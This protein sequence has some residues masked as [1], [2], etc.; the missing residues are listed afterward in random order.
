MQRRDLIKSAIIGA[1]GLQ[2]AACTTAITSDQA[3]SD[4]NTKV[5]NK[6]IIKPKPLKFGDT[7]AIIAPGTN[8]PTPEALQKVQEVI[9]WLGLKAKY[10]EYLR[11]DFGY[12]TRT[13]QTRATEFMQA[14]AD[15]SVS[16]VFCIRGGYGC[17]QIL[18]LIDYDLIRNNPKIFAGYSDIT[19]LHLAIAQRSRLVTLHAPVMKSEFT[20]FTAEHFKD[21]I[22]AKAEYPLLLQ[23]P[24]SKSGIR[25]LFPTRTITGGK[26]RGKMIGGNLS[27]ISALMGTPYEIQTDGYILF[28]ED[29]GEAPYSIDRMLSQLELGGK[30]KKVR[31]IIFGQCEGC[32]GSSSTWDKS[33][34]EVL[35]YYFKPLQIPVFYGLLFGHSDNQLTMPELCEVEI[36]ADNQTLTLLENPMAV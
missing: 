11:T 24:N 12:K 14:F 32:T 9:D 1:V 13:A 7:V 33:L 36:D 22:F 21:I 29:V 20:N 8:D 23:N 34:G 17:Q 19:A 15:E 35:D 30:F 27:L 16:G 2:L 25:A 26:V 3:K 10:T 28:L 18:E 5:S 31:G 4:D 6:P